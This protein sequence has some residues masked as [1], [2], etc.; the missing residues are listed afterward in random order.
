MGGRLLTL[1]ASFA[2]F[3]ALLAAAGCAGYGGSE[4]SPYNGTNTGTGTGG[5]GI[6]SGPAAGDERGRQVRGGRYEPIRHDVLRSAVDVRGR[7]RH[8]ELR[9][10]PPRREPRHAPQP[11]SVRL[12]EYV[13]DFSYDYP[14]PTAADPNPFTISLGAA[15]GMFDRGTA[16]LRVGIRAFEPPRGRQAAHEPRVPGRRVRQHAQ[17]RQAAAGAAHPARHAGDPRA[18][19]HGVDRQLRG[20][21]AGPPGTDAGL[22]ERAHRH[23]HRRAQ[24][25][26]QHGGRGGPDARVPAGP[27]RLHRRRDQPH[28][29]VHGRRLQRRAGDDRRAAGDREAG[30]RFRRHADRARVRHRQ[31]E[32]PDDGGGQR[33]RERR[34]RHDQQP[35]AGRPVR[36]RADAL[37][38]GARREQHE[39]P[40]AVQRVAGGGVPPA[41]LRGPRRRGQRLPQRQG[42]RRRGRRRPPRDRALRAGADRDGRFRRRRARPTSWKVRR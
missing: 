4:G 31:P 42:R 36:V 2:A 17:R 38:A 16:L 23:R 34:L 14:A 25:R 37:D 8:G 12:E 10:P 39:G 30:A 35:D 29:A 24:R 41:R 20:R 5:I 11:A 15:A 22:A 19:R 40:G 21:H 13:N 27:R 32:R 6:G 3:C 28:P 1:I 18:D 9:H 7:R 26:R 33:R